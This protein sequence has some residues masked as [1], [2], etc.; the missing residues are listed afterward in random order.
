M[1][2]FTVEI[3][4]TLQ[5]QIE[6]EAKSES[7]AIS[8]VKEMYSNEEV[9]LDSG[10][11]IDTEFE[12]LEKEEERKLITLSD[13]PKEIHASLDDLDLEDIDD[14]QKVGDAIYDYILEKYDIEPMSW[15]W[16]ISDDVDHIDIYDIE[17]FPTEDDIHRPDIDDDDEMEQH[18][19]EYLEREYHCEVESFTFTYDMRRVYIE[20]IKWKEE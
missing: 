14:Y 6:V 13:L 4:E 16:E 19:R 9:V 8:K 1:K 15:N 2:K 17:W 12:V 7:D 11:Y 20:N 10:D 5:R 18:I 3:T